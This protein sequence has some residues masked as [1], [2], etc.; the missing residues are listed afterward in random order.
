M[1]LDDDKPSEQSKKI[2]I[3][4]VSSQKSIF[5]DAPKKPSQEDLQKNAKKAEENFSENKTRAYQLANDFLRAMEDK[6][7]PENKNVFQKDMEKELLRNMSNLAQEINSDPLELD[8]VG[9]LS[10]IVLLLKTCL[11]QRDKI[12]TLEYNV[13]DKLSKIEKKLQGLDNTPKS[14]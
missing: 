6:T 4:K 5:D 14:E 8:G 1:P 7:L 9:S 13:R 2:G 11:T 10:W 12:N 3:R